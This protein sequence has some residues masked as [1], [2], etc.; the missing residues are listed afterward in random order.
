M[1]GAEC[2]SVDRF[3]NLPGGPMAPASPG[4]EKAEKNLMKQEP[5]VLDRVRRDFVLQA[6]RSVC[7]C[8][9]WELCAA[10][11]RTSHLHVVVSGDENPQ[12]I[13]VDF[14]AYASRALNDAGIDPPRRKRWSRH[15]SMRYLWKREDVSAARDYVLLGQGVPMT[16]F[17][18]M[19]TSAARVADSKEAA[20]GTAR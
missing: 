1:H 18:A 7:N 8:R 11:I 5:Y 6:I 14:K 19:N 2:G 16:V 3:H 12:R 13:M 9:G 17:D 4:R 15:G 20:G 10:H